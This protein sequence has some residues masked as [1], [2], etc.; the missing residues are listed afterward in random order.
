VISA[1]YA[2][3]LKTNKWQQKRNAVWRKAEG[4]CGRCGGWAHGGQVHHKTYE[5]I[6]NEPLTDLQLLCRYCHSFIHGHSTYDPLHPP[7]W[8]ELEK[9]LLQE[10]RKKNDGCPQWVIDGQLPSEQRRPAT[11]EECGDGGDVGDLR[12]VQPAWNKKARRLCRRCASN[13]LFKEEGTI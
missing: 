12:I 13:Y 7:S 9:Q 1:E 10:P 5:H 4:K 8:E 3:Y 11:C 6:F 2:E